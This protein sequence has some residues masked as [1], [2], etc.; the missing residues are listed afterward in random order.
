[1][2]DKVDGLDERLKKFKEMELK[3]WCLNSNFELDEKSNLKKLSVLKI[4]FQ[5]QIRI[6]ISLQTQITNHSS[7]SNYVHKFSFSVTSRLRL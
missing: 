2:I 1:M 6:R 5:A 7:F 3:N 4:K